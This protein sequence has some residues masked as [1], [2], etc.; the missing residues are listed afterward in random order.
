M[1]SYGPLIGSIDQGTSSTRF[2][3]FAASTSQ[4]ITFHQTPVQTYSPH[5]GWSEQDPNELLDSVVECINQTCSKLVKL[6]VDPGDIKAIGLANQRETTIVWDKVTGAPL[7]PAILWNDTRTESV[8]KDILQTES[9]FGDRRQLESV[10][11][12]RLDTNPSSQT[13]Q[14]TAGKKTVYK[15]RSYRPDIFEL[16]EFCGLPLST[17]FSALKLVWLKE[18]VAEVQQKMDQDQLLFGTVDSW[19]IWNLTGGAGGGGQHLTDV[20]NASRTLLMN[21]RTLDW[22]PQLLEFFNLPNNILPT[23]KSSSEYFGSLKCSRLVGVPIT[24]CLGDQQAALLGHQCTAPGQTKATFGTGCFVLTNIGTLP[25]IS[26]G[27]ITTVAYKFGDGPAH[28]ALEGSIG[29]A[30]SAFKVLSSIGI[31]KR[32]MES[33]TT[34][35][36]VQVLP[37]FSVLLAPRWRPET[38]GLI[39]GISGYTMPEHI[40]YATLEA[41]AFQVKEILGCIETSIGMSIRE[42]EADGG[43]SHCDNLLQT[44]ADLLGIDV[45]RPSMVETTALGAAIAA[46]TFISAWHSGSTTKNRGIF[47]SKNK[48]DQPSTERFHPRTKDDERCR[49]YSRWKSFVDKALRSQPSPTHS[50]Q[51]FNCS[52]PG[53]IFLFSSFLLWVLSNHL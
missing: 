6:D 43:L 50:S 16:Q 49:R 8:L 3:V 19:L 25:V 20:T 9:V 53:S 18:N 41:L 46:G 15:H 35:A 28:F 47:S 13:E 48:N 30:G 34:S 33:S 32:L 7:H 12:D 22:E 26:P 40:V 24:G 11:G 31:D 44:Q 17:Y 38:R 52:L 45:V 4:L 10:L 14:R 21:I 36:G 37:A 39:A 27:L 42:I 29:D 1:K 5:P 51:E 23:I 2:M